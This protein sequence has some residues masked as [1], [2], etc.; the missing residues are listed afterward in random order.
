[1]TSKFLGLPL[2]ASSLLASSVVLHAQETFSTPSGQSTVTFY[3]QVTPAITSFD[4]G[5]TTTTTLTDNGSSNTRF[6]FNVDIDYPDQGALRL[7]FETALGLRQSSGISQV[8]TPDA[9][10][11][12]RTD[13]RKIEAIWTADYGVLSIGQGSMASD[14]V[15]GSDFSGVGLTN[16]VAVSDPAGSFLFRQTDGT[17]SG[18]AINDVFSDLDGARRARIRYDTPSFSGFSIGAAYGQNVL[19]SGDDDDYYDTALRYA[20]DFGTTKVQA[21]LAYAFRDRDSADD[22]EDLVGSA[23]VLLDNGLNF[24]VASGARQKGGDGSYLY[25]KAGWIGNFW[26]VGSSHF[27]IDWN[28]AED[29][30]GTNDEAT[31]IGIG[32]TQKFDDLSLEGY[33]G[34]REYTFEDDAATYQDASSLIF[35]SRWRF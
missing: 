20:N 2:A 18:V 6:G 31:A 28:R 25:L 12:E 15:A 13:L 4:D 10:D 21:A 3:G 27:A 11:F 24:S 26:S 35:G 1:M 32:N 17:L 22:S 8:S 5:Q 16:A 30:N 33:L 19:T 7:N 34:Y 14:G 9:W 29:F 23:A